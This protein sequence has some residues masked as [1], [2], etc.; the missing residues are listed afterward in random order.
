[1]EKIADH[2]NVGT[3]TAWEM[4]DEEPEKLSES[5]FWHIEGS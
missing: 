4:F 2:R 5:E 3:D 1:M